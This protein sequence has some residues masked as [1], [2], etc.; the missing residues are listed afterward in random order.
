MNTMRESQVLAA[1]ML[2][3]RRRRHRRRRLAAAPSPPKFWVRE[4]FA[5]REQLGEFHTLVQEMRTSDRESF[6]RWPI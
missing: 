1:V 3:L 4:I 5:K 2:L 6:F